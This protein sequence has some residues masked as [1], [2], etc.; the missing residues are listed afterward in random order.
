MAIGEEG[1][2]SPFDRAEDVERRVRQRR[3][4][5]VAAR[6]QR[7]R[8]FAREQRDRHEFRGTDA[9]AAAGHALD[10]RECRMRG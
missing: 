10:G 8:A 5:D 3:D 4:V 1:G 9:P 2:A 6:D 7:L